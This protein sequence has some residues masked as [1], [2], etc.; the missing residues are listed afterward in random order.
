MTIE[1][2]LIT[3]AVIVFGGLFAGL[4]LAFRETEAE[5]AAAS[6][7]E[8]TTQPAP[9]LYEWRARNEALTQEIMV[10]QLEHYLRREAMVAEQFL[11]DPSPKTLRAG[12]RQHLGS[13]ASH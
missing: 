6:A 11:I 4:A 7:A 9:G 5:R 1:F 2:Y 10:R 12:E 13:Y 8:K 3:L